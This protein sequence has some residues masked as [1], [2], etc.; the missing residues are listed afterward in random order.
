MTNT[1]GND[2]IV[3][4]LAR[5]AGVLAMACRVDQVTLEAAR[6]HQASPVA[7]A[8]LGNGLAAAALLGS[9]LK[10][11][12]RIA[13]KV[14]GNGPLQKM[15]VE[16]DS[17]GRLRGYVANPQWDAPPPISAEE[18]AGALGRVG[19]LTVVKDLG[20]KNLYEGV[21]PLQT[22]ELDKDLMYYLMQSEQVLSL[23]EI[24]ADID[25]GGRLAAA[26][27][28]LLQ[29]MPGQDTAVLE[30]L[31]ERTEDLP[32]IAGML[33]GGVTPADVLADLFGDVSYEVLETHPLVFHCSCSRERSLQAL[34]LLDRDDLLGLI[35]EGEAVIDCHFCHEQYVFDRDVLEE[36]L[37]QSA[38]A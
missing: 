28:F 3:R 33:A 22:G 6:R 17:Y 24:G 32:P 5:E 2:H 30:Q 18:V 1:T 31:V 16:S 35:A 7:T 8:A 29:A 23:L 27:G 34:R 14:E 38:S 10:V 26:G 15:I 21:V 12:Q 11:Q 25:A 4:A 36:V 20:I 37:A 9:L 19:L 13:I